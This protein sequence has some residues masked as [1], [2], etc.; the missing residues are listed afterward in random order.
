MSVLTTPRYSS[1]SSV[2]AF[3]EWESQQET[4]HELLNGLII[5]MTGGTFAHARLIARLVTRLS[6][7]LDDTPCA[8]L[9]SDFKVQ[10]VNDVFYPDVLVTCARQ[11]NEDLLC[12]EPKLIIEVLSN[13]TAHKDRFRKRQAYQQISSLEEYILVSQEIQHV[14]IY[15][16]GENWQAE[17]HTSGKVELRSVAVLLDIDDLYASIH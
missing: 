11:E 6:N 4:K 17:I 9:S 3:I 13:S 8:V 14:E 15:R 2:E 7:A 5:A 16:R 1:E 10:A 12:K